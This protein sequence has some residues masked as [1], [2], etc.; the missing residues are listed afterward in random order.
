MKSLISV[1]WLFEHKD[2]PDLVILDASPKQNKSHLRAEYPTLKIKGARFFDMESCFLD[3]G[4]SIPNMFP[5]EK[6]FAKECRKLGITYNSN[7]VVYDNLGIYT[8]PRVWWMFKA[9]GHKNIGV[10]DGGLLA[11]KNENFEC[12]ARTSDAL[13]PGE[14]TANFNSDFIVDSEQVLENI[15]KKKW[16]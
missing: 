5:S 7:I 14:F 11:W 2:H 10:L 1:N 3:K 6:E 15:S 16:F 12:E 8:S 13:S 4:S 9:M